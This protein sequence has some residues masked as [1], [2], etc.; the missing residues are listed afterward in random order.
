MIEQKV[1]SV[2]YHLKRP[3]GSNIFS[4][5]HIALLK[6]FHG[7]NLEEMTSLLPPL[8]VEGHPIVCPSKVVAYRQIKQRGKTMKQV[9]WTGLPN[10][11]R[12]WEDI[13]SIER[14]MSGENLEDKISEKVG[15]DVTVRLELDTVTKRL[16]ADLAGHSG[17]G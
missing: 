10:D 8:A 5:F 16:Q 7:S 1:S 6:P 4:V 9:E 13:T 3:V 12:S 15:R 17:A 11:D 14:L 2:A